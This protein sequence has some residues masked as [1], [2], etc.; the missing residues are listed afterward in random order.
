MTPTRVIFSRALGALNFVIG[1]WTVPDYERGFRAVRSLDGGIVGTNL[2]F[3]SG[4]FASIWW[5]RGQW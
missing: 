3:K 4:R 1:Q 2:T 5:M